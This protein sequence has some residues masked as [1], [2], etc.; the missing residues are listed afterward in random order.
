[1]RNP[2]AIYRTEVARSNIGLPSDDNNKRNAQT[3]SNF[4]KFCCYIKIWKQ[5]SKLTNDKDKKKT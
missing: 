4:S 1:M 2:Q 5:Y 3:D